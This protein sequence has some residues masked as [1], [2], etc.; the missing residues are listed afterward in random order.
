MASK[1]R[2]MFQKNKTQETTENVKSTNRPGKDLSLE[3][4]KP[5]TQSGGSARTDLLDRMRASV[6]GWPNSHSCAQNAILT[7]NNDLT[8]TED[9]P[10]SVN[11]DLKMSRASVSNLTSCALRQGTTETNY[12]FIDKC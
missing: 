12:Q 3:R 1:R 11:T 4:T 6:A 9:P 5:S 10:D 8:Q 2:N 7:G